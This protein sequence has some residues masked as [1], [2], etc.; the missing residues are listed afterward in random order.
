[1]TN[2]LTHQVIENFEFLNSVLVT[3]SVSIGVFVLLFIAMFAWMVRAYYLEEQVSESEQEEVLE[4][5]DA[6][7][8]QQGL[9]EDVETIPAAFERGVADKMLS[10]GKTQE[11]IAYCKSLLDVYPNDTDIHWVLGQA[12]F[13]LD[14]YYQSIAHYKQVMKLNPY[15]YSYAKDNIQEIRLK[16]KDESAA[17][18][19]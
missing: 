18:L 10:Q 5:D 9:E 8:I 16:M 1:M 4:E 14:D 2:E 15:L 11:A 19:H 13:Q 6:E 12:N 3:L 7:P 17:Q